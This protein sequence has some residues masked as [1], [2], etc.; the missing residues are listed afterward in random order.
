MSKQWGHGFWSGFRAAK[1]MEQQNDIPQTHT[2]AERIWDTLYDIMWRIKKTFSRDK[3]YGIDVMCYIRGGPGPNGSKLIGMKWHVFCPFH[4]R[5]EE[6]PTLIF[7]DP[8]AYGL[9]YTPLLGEWSCHSCGG[10]GFVSEY[11]GGGRDVPGRKEDYIIY[12]LYKL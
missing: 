3:L 6:M 10:H 5:R 9:E 12:K 2:I 11:G 8:Y 1:E 7:N 4:R